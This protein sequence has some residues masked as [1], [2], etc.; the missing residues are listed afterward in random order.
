MQEPAETSKAGAMS[1]EPRPTVCS[2]RNEMSPKT[3]VP[4]VMIF[5]PVPV[6]VL[7]GLTG[8]KPLAPELIALP[9]RAI[10]PIVAVVIPPR[11]G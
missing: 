5:V 2:G 11:G 6:G 7:T 4:M 8:Q 9:G 3:G 10:W 1:W